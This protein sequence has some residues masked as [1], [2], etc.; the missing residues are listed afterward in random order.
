MS[1]SVLETPVVLIFYRRPDT[2]RR[3]W[4]RIREARPRKLFL[5]ADSPRWPE[6]EAACQAARAVVEDVDWPCEVIRDYAAQN[7]GCRRRVESGLNHV[8]EQ[9]EEA[10]ILED[11]CLPDPTFFSYCQELLA[12]Y[13]EEPRVMMISGTNHVGSKSLLQASYAFTSYASIWGWATWR[14]AWRQ[15][16]PTIKGWYRFRDGGGMEKVFAT[17][18]EVIAWTR[19]FDRAYN[20]AWPEGWDHE[21][22]ASMLIH[23]GLSIM[24]QVNLIEN[25]GFGADA[26]HTFAEE[27]GPEAPPGEAISFPLRHPD[28]VAVDLTAGTTVF[29]QHYM[30]G[31]RRPWRERVRSLL[32]DSEAY[33]EW[34]NADYRRV[35]RELRRL[36]AEPR[37]RPG[38]SN[39]LVPAIRY[40]DGPSLA[41]R[42]EDVFARELD[43]FRCHGPAPVI[44]DGCAD[45]GL[46]LLYWKRLYPD[47]RIRAYEAAPEAFACLRDNC[48]RH[49]VEDVMLVPGVLGAQEGRLSLT[50]ARGG[51]GRM[52][53]AATEPADDTIEV[54][55]VPLTPLLKGKIDFLKLAVEEGDVT[56]LE[57]A[58]GG[59]AQVRRIAVVCPA[60]VGAETLARVLGVLEAVGFQ[61]R[62]ESRQCMQR[63][64]TPPLTRD[65]WQQAVFV[66]GSWA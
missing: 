22:W 6:E 7:L 11:D 19:I 17:K 16:D 38:E 47:A 5:V 37:W 32:H 52:V 23:G 57:S 49:D 21:W 63:P 12:R 35:R 36:A 28:K 26:T 25:I 56:A 9:V 1:E 14:R 39:L 15:N 42:Y 29:E 50:R 24:P 58:Q 20:R 61:I 31:S 46:S 30:R 53:A 33:K 60:S 10:I 66:Y 40:L 41:I 51:L 62:V 59:L 18:P 65:D 3:V 43:H 45:V 48:Q 4:Q 13:R 8:F 64:L 54:D 55:V 27:G 2:T 44:V 34:R